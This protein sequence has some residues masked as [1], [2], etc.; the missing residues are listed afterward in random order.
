[1]L[2]LDDSG[3]L[4]HSRKRQ[5]NQTLTQPSNILRKILK[6]YLINVNA[7]LMKCTFSRTVY[8]RALKFLQ[9]I[10]ENVVC[11]LTQ[12]FFIDHFNK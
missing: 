11:D 10:Y 5:W 8:S 7:T 4:D 3:G 6:P 2:P 9:V 1:M 12:G